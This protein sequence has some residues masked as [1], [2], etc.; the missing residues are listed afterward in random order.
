MPRLQRVPA[1]DF[2]AGQSLSVAPGNVLAMDGITGWLELNGFVR[3]STVREAGEYA[4]RGGIIDLYAPGMA[5]PVRLDF[6]GDTLEIDP[7]L[8]SREPA[9]HRPAARHSISSRPPSSSSRPRPSSASASAMSRRSARPRP[10][11][12]STRR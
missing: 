10:T 5:E 6:F 2:V 7:Q 4:V 11:I 1:R 9:H 12:C 8:R 3:A